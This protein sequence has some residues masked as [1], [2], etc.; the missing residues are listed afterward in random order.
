MHMQVRSLNRDDF[1]KT[2]M[3]SPS[4]VRMSREP[5]GLFCWDPK[6]CEKATVNT[7]SGYAGWFAVETMRERWS[8]APG[9]GSI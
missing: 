8:L 3:P 7:G 2:A 4:L 6:A 1:L 5:L 9:M